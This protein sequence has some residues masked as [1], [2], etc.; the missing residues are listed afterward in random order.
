MTDNLSRKTACE[1]ASLIASKA[2]SPV[3]VLDAH[4]ET[5]ARVNPKLNA[6]VTLVADSAREQAKQAEA[7]VMNG[8]KLGALH[9]LP[10]VIK[11]VTP[12]KG[13]R[14]TYGSPRFKD[15]VPTEDAEAVRRLRAHGAIVLGKTNTPEFAAGANTFNDVFG[16]TR[17]PWNPALSPSG[18]SGGSAVAVATGMVPLA[19]GTDFGCSI[20]MPASFNGIVGIRPTPGLT[21]NWPMPMA[22]DPGQ[23]HGPLAR[24]AE[25]A[26]LM[27][28]ALVGYSRMSPI[29]VAPPWKSARAIVADVKDLKGLRIAYVSD[30]SGIGVD[31]EIDVICRACAMSLA[32]AGAS[33]EEIKFDIADGKEPYQAWRGLWMVGQQYANLDQLEE[34]GVN[35]KGNVKAGLKVTP[36]DFAAS[37]QKRQ[38]LFLRFAKFFESYDLLITP[39]S[40]VKQFPV[41]MNFPTEI[42][43]KK[44]DNYT[45]WIAGSFLITLMSLPG[46]AVPAGMTSDGLPVGIQ[47][48]GPRFEEPLILSA[49]KIV[50]QLHPLGWPTHG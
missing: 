30:I 28:D 32:S 5:I 27:L 38:E 33:V 18:S 3:E 8:D 13:I 45:D 1:L 26:A 7:A 9:G 29:S 24:T 47:I 40:P 4:L 48:V 23:V 11:D 34:F 2:V 41:E 6:I 14:T 44:L 49:M 39:Q 50:Q 12:T 20:R 19:Q 15:H 25:D 31:P 35:L 43:G 17:N 10:V 22:W 46:G 16:V 37:E 42:N 21:P 36:L